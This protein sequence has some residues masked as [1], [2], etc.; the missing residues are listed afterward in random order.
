MNFMRMQPLYMHLTNTSLH[1]ILPTDQTNQQ[2]LP[3]SASSREISARK[4][5]LSQTIH[6][7]C[8]RNKRNA[9]NKRKMTQASRQVQTQTQQQ[10]Q[11]LSPQQV[12]VVKLL[13]LPAIEL[14][15]RVRAELLENPALEEG[16]EETSADDYADSPDTDR[17]SPED[18][19]DTD[20]DSLSDYLTE[21]DIP[22]YKL[23]ENNR[24]RDDKAEEIPFSDSTSFYETL[25]EQLGEQNLTPHQRDY[26]KV[27]LKNFVNNE[28]EPG[29][30]LSIYILDDEIQKTRRP[31]F[32]MCKMRDGSDAQKFT[33]NQHLMAKRF[34][35]KFQGPLMN[36]IDET[37][38]RKK[39]ADSSPIFETLQTISVNSF[40]KYQTEGLRR[41]VM[42]SDM[43]HYTPQYSMFT[44]HHSFTSLK[45]SDYYSQIKTFLPDTAVKLYFLST[46]PQYQKQ[47][48]VEFWKKYFKDTSA[49][50]DE[51]IP[52]GR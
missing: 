27:H 28:I 8:A 25:K 17:E 40:D 35:K 2:N 22:D 44:P 11:T 46:Y 29:E 23:Q 51:V 39:S 1:K 16:K 32:E 41:L 4:V 30:L 52:V 20:Y 12:L 18:G 24:S 49:F 42:F 14:E 19:G 34:Q 43:L 9:R 47:E 10:V 26:L 15:D 33:E 50:V 36:R 3:K 6:Y 13:E 37:L 5:S 45:E 31:I 21:D 38:S 7:I 48:L